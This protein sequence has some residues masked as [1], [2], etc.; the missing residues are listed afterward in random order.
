MATP[1]SPTSKQLSRVNPKTTW[2]SI[3]TVTLTGC[4]VLHVQQISPLHLLIAPQAQP[5]LTK[6]LTLKICKMQ[7]LQ[8]QIQHRLDTNSV[9]KSIP[10]LYPSWALLAFLQQIFRW[11]L[12]IQLLSPIGTTMWLTIC[13]VDSHSAL[14][15]QLFKA[16]F[17]TGMLVGSLSLDSF[18]IK[19]KSQSLL[20]R[21]QLQHFNSAVIKP[22]LQPYS[23]HHLVL[24]LWR[25]QRSTEES[26]WR[27]LA[28]ESLIQAEPRALN[29]IKALT[30]QESA[31]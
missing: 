10:E 29:T 4:G 1:F 5:M 11:Q 15:H 19:T 7:V 8:S 2:H 6:T 14:A 26:L 13:L 20:Q 31:R 30:L 21:P 27:D 16:L 28:L 22:L 12:S 3:Q 24:N 9:D 25:L 18:T 17:I 23:I